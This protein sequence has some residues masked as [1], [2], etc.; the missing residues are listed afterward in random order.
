[1]KFP[2]LIAIL[3]AASLSLLAALSFWGAPAGTRWLGDGIH[4]SSDVAVYLS[5]LKQGADGH[6]LLH[7]LYAV[8]PN[9]GRFDAVWSLLGFV[10]R[11]NIDPV[12]IHEVARIA[13]SMVLVIALWA[14]VKSCT[15]KEPDARLAL[16]LALG[17]VS[18]GWIYSIWLGAKGLWTPMTYAAPDIVTEFAVGPILMGGAHAILSLALLMT[19]L[20][21]LWDGILNAKQRETLLGSLAGIGLLSF[22][23]YFAVLLGAI[24][25]F[26]WILSRKR[27]ASLKLLAVSGAVLILPLLYYVWLIRDPVFGGHHIQDNILP[28]AP[29]TVWIQTLLPFLGAGVWMWRTKHLPKQIEWTHAWLLTSILLLL[30]LP[31]PWKRKL[32]EGLSVALVLVTLPAWLAVRDWV[33]S[34]HPRW[35]RNV[36]AGLLLLAAWF[37]P[38]HILVSHLTWINRPMEQHFF[39]QPITLFDAGRFLHNHAST[40]AVLLSDDVWVNTWL[41]ALSGRTVWIGHDHETPHFSEKRAL[42]HAFLDETDVAKK[43]ELLAQIPVTYLVLT[44]EDGRTTIPPALG[45]E[46]TRVFQSGTVDVWKRN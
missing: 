15:K 5:Y 41:P 31:V 25:L 20:R 10:A 33:I 14:A 35:M 45:R 24:G 9:V 12:I 42:Y 6:L 17:G 28:L 19:A 11:S 38:V 27:W 29:L 8:E 39:Y 43:Q 32:T 30:L 44:T 2:T 22:H 36:L 18:T 1:M 23:P 3:I 7:D 46:W 4:N 16:L 21:L 34:Q 40:H 37:G 26:A 13:F